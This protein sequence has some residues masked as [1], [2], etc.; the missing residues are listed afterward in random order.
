MTY[1]ADSIA[2]CRIRDFVIAA[3]DQVFDTCHGTV[4]GGYSKPVIW[5]ESNGI[6]TAF[7]AYSFDEDQRFLWIDLLFVRSDQRKLGIGSGLLR[8]ILDSA[9]QMHAGTVACNVN[10]QN[11]VMKHVLETRGFR[12]E[13]D[14]GPFLLASLRI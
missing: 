2:D 12:F 11:T 4:L 6:P 7:L 14:E 5:T 1:S 10:S 13:A 8:S 9:A 3:F